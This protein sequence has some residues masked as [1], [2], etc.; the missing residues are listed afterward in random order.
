MISVLPNYRYV[1]VFTCSY[2]DMCLCLYHVCLH[3]HA[4]ITLYLFRWLR[5]HDPAFSLVYSF[6]RF[7]SLLAHYYF[8]LT[9]L[10]EYNC[11]KM[12]YQFLLYNKVNQLYIYIYP[13]ISSLFHFPPTLPI[14]PFQVVTQH[15]ADL[16][17]RC[18]LIFFT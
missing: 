1:C 3:F 11:F 14:L 13:H 18:Q 17:V 12:V 7:F 9:S 16:P 5:A 15:R 6:Q 4:A 10:L 8:F 2:I